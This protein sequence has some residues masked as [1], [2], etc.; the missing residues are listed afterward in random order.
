MSRRARLQAATGQECPGF[1]QDN[2]TAGQEITTGS[3]SPTNEGIASC[4]QLH[5]GTTG[6]RG[7]DQG[8]QERS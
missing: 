6:H 8:S 7:G 3:R 1:V 5:T 2:P 4:S